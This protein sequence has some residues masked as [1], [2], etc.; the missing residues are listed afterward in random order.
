[1]MVVFTSRSEKKAVYTVRRILDSFA[2]RIGTDT[3]K[4]IITADGLEAVHTLLRKNA[5]KSMAVSCQWIRSRSR[6]ELVWVVGNRDAFSTSGIIPVN[7]TRKN[8]NHEE[9]ENNWHYMPLLKALVAMAALFH[10][11]GK[12]SDYFQKK[13]KDRVLE[14]DPYR[15]EWI[16]CKLMEGLVYITAS[17]A[18]DTIWLEALKNDEVDFSLLI[19]YAKDNIKISD[20]GEFKDSL[21]SLP[22]VEKIIC[23]LILSH[24]RLPLPNK[25]EGYSDDEK[26]LFSELWKSITSNWGYKNVRFENAE[27]FLKCFSFSCGMM[28]INTSEWTKCVKKWSARLLEC[29]GSHEHIFAKEKEYAGVFKSLIIYSH[30]CLV[31]ADHYISSLKSER[32]QDE[33]KIPFLWANTRS[34]GYNQGLE[35]HLVRVCKQAV[36]IAHNLPYLSKNMEVVTDN[37]ALKKKSP[38]Q[39]RW[40]DKAVD[41]I[42]L[43]RKENKKDTAYFIVNMASTGC[44]KTYANAKIMQAVSEKSSSLRYILALGLRSLTLQ[45]GDEYKERIGLS[46]SELAVLIGSSAITELHNEEKASNGEPALMDE[47]ESLLTEDIQYID[48]EDLEQTKFLNVF[49][50][51]DNS[52]ILTRRQAYKNHAL[53]YKPVLVSTIDHVMGA[54]E[55]I[56]GGRFILPMMRLMSSDLVIDEIDD[57]DPRD[58]IAICRLIHLA[59]I[60]GRNVAISSATIPPDLAEVLYRSY[61]TGL[62]FYSEFHKIGLSIASVHCDE[63]RCHIESLAEAKHTFRD[64]H[65]EFI[66]KRVKKLRDQVARRKGFIKEIDAGGLSRDDL[67]NKKIKEYFECMKGAAE[68]LHCAHHEIDKPTGKKVSFGII[69]VAHIDT[70][71]ALTKYLLNSSWNENVSARVMAYHS[72]QILL[73]R[74][75]Q[76]KYLDAVLRRKEQQEKVFEFT[77]S[78]VRKHLDTCKEDN[79]LFIVVATPV[80]EVGRDHDADWAIIEPSSYRSIIQLAGRVRRHRRGSIAVEDPNIAVMQFNIAAMYGRN[81]VFSRPGYESSTHIVEHDLKKNVDVQKL[82]ERIDAIP[83]I[84]KKQEIYPQKFLVDLE[85]LVM[86]DLNDSDATGPSV[87]NG[88]IR[89]SWWMT[90]IPQKINQFRKSD[91]NDIKAIAVYKDGRLQFWEYGDKT[92]ADRT[93]IYDISLDKPLSEEAIEGLWIRRNY[94]ELLGKRVS[95]TDDEEAELIK[96]AKIYGEIVLNENSRWLYSDQ[97]GLFREKGGVD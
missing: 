30:L 91:G 83:R 34:T 86:E 96:I 47:P 39:Y 73:L 4:A 11:I 8:I 45:T 79:I 35:E 13:L 69:R 12:A 71:V 31:L 5:T 54:T 10:D 29:V 58:L 95:D 6:S 87:V 51:T 76:E 92:E 66:R 43:F 89:E 70:C 18:D 1:M 9:W 63:F 72:R 84:E 62:S 78:I 28:G 32:R 37:K 3:W 93:D 68:R 81:V 80:E 55:T 15:H 82:A 52:R 48:T 88:W 41:E 57:F 67:L 36:Q 22:P 46:D 20:G 19:E 56:R 14:A 90:G 7:T 25:Y 85:H 65:Y 64:V 94:R 38:V 74:H 59:G 50:D 42:S 40:Q 23:Y 24:H 77:D 49:F 53:L 2:D 60:F 97:F 26:T 44:G 21:K 75:E 61:V 16:S 27:G 17:E 33:I